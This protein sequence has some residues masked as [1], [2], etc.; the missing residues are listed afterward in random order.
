MRACFRKNLDDNFVEIMNRLHMLE[1]AYNF[2]DIS[3]SRNPS[4]W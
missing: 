3:N 1:Q 4:L 2:S